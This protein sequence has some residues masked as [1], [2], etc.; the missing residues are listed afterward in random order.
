MR[1]ITAVCMFMFMIMAC[2]DAEQAAPALSMAGAYKM[3][4]VSMKNATTDTTDNA[5]NQMK[6][7][8]PDHIIYAW[9]NPADSTGGFGIGTYEA[10]GDSVNE[11]IMYTSNVS[12]TNDTLRDF[13]LKI[14]KDEMGGYTQVI[15]GITVGGESTVMTESYD[16]AGTATTTPLD[17]AWKLKE[18]YVIN[19]S[20]TTKGARVQYKVFYAGNVIWGTSFADSAG[21]NHTGIG[22]GRFELN[23]NQL[24]ESPA[25]STFSAVTGHEFDI[26]IEMNGD[27]EF[28]QTITDDD[29][30]K[31][32]EVYIRMK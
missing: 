26:A 8:T 27:D 28:K 19:G 23:G 5:P 13:T 18:A 17:G 24:K 21:T 25:L 7:Y 22:Y 31:S 9:V 1:L 20:D 15:D 30:S 16:N 12:T 11:H 14:Q 2:N 29:G 3:T 6:I 4:T 32:V 10:A